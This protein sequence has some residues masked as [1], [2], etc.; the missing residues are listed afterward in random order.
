MVVFDV[1]SRAAQATVPNNFRK[2][3]MKMSLKNYAEHD[4]GSSKEH[5]IVAL[6][7]EFNI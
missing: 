6:Q 5:S 7:E 2:C 4:R 1:T 3:I